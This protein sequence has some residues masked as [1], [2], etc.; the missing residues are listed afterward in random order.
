MNT[1]KHI[2]TSTNW[3]FTSQKERW[4]SSDQVIDAYLKGKNEGLE[5]GQKLILEQLIRNLSKTGNHTSEI[6]QFL[7]ASNFHPI[8]AF[9]KINSWDDFGILIVLPESE[10]IAPSIIDVY[11]F[12]SEFEN[13]ITEEFYNVHIQFCCASEQINEK[14]IESDGFVLKHIH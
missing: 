11:D 2:V 9:L 3:N 8:S 7:N 4:Y 10:F 13:R 14:S 12:I 1:S 5:Q 6:I